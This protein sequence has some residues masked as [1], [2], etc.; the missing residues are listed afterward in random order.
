MGFNTATSLGWLASAPEVVLS[1]WTVAEVSSALSLHVRRESLDPEERDVA[2]NN[3][4]AWLDMGFHVVEV[5]PVDVTDARDLIHRHPELRTPDALH[6]AIVHRLGAGLATY[7]YD[8][9]IAAGRDGVEV[10]AP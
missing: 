2:E 5:D 10:I 7:D 4:N 3:L 8:L 9:S 6:L 1:D